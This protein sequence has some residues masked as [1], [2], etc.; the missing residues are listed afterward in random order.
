MIKSEISPIDFKLGNSPIQING[1]N[2]G[3]PS[4]EKPFEIK[5]NQTRDM[6]EL[7]NQ[8][9]SSRTRKSFTT[10]EGKENNV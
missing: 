1:L 5:L 7:L 3:Q 2:I 4:D 10:T 6:D 9:S 8:P